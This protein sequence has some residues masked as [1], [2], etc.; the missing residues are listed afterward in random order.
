MCGCLILRSAPVIANMLT[1]VSPWQ[2]KD[3]D[4]SDSWVELGDTLWNY[5]WQQAVNDVDPDIVEI[6]M[7]NCC[8][9]VSLFYNRPPFFSYL[10]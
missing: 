1:A 6:G 10:E 4:P 7:L 5:R 9:L 3:T 2:F 8:L